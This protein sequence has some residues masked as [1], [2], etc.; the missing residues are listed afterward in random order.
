MSE[1]LKSYDDYHDLR[2]DGRIV[3]YK[4]KSH[5]RRPSYNVRIKFPEVRGYII[6]STKSSDL[7][8]SKLFAN[9]LYWELEGKL[10]RGESLKRIYFKQVIGGWKTF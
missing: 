2:N 6:K 1:N 10:K 5:K 8:E 9:N 4:R 7:E 3:L